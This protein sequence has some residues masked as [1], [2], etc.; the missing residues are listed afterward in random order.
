[1]MLNESEIVVITAS[2][3][4]EPGAAYYIDL[5]IAELLEEPREELRF[6]GA[7]GGD[8][9]ALRAAYA[10]RGEYTT[11]LLSVYVPSLVTDQPA[12]AQDAIRECADAVFELGQ[13]VVARRRARSHL[14]RHAAL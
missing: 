7:R 4:L 12:S 8:T 9:I 6:G 14:G 10:A 11:P 5:A 3:E 1:M 13:P 2:R